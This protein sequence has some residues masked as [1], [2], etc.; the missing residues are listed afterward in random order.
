MSENGQVIYQTASVADATPHNIEA[1]QAVLGSLLI[2]PDAFF[3]VDT[4]ISPE[5][6]YSASHGEIYKAIREIHQDKQVPDIITVT[7][8]LRAQ[9]TAECHG[10]LIEVYLSELM[11]VVPSSFGVDAYAKIVINDAMRR[12][13]IRAGREISSLAANGKV[14]L[15]EMVET[16]QQTLFSVTEKTATRG[17]QSARQV[18]SALVDVVYERMNGDHQVGMKTGFSDLDKMLG[19]LKPKDVVLLA[20]RPGMGKSVLEGLISLYVAQHYGGVARFNLEMSSEQ[21][22]MRLL[23]SASRIP[24]WNIEHGQ[25]AGD[26]I[27]FFNRAAG[28][29]SSLPLFVDDT[30]GLTIAQLAAKSRRLHMEHGLRLITLDYVQLMG[31][32]RSYGNRNQDIGQIS[33]G[34]KGLAKELN[35]PILV[36]A[37]LSRAVENRAE[38]RPLLSDLRDSGEL[39]QDADLVLFLYRDEYYNPDTTMRPNVAE[40]NIAKHRNGPTG[41]V[42]LYFHGPTMTFRNL[43]RQTI[44]L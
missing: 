38:K 4:M 5:Q 6:F 29:I 31:I 34:L 23:S 16:S 27:E 2:D 11:D 26:E 39:E 19:G 25:F 8:R 32:E 13:L 35:I 9:G 22:I 17:V 12:S 7:A 15:D 21:V 37:Q 24:Y 10:R 44:N 43:A 40:I 41:T 42:D 33:R 14:S 3:M 36:L 18:V 30:P 28:E 20:A 1:E